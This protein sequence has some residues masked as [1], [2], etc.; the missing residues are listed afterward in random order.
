MIFLLLA[1]RM[2]I[3]RQR[4]RHLLPPPAN[5]PVAYHPLSSLHSRHISLPVTMYGTPYV[6]AQMKLLL[7]PMMQQYLP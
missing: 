3:H 4:R 2:V 1:D 6:M 5:F 7:C